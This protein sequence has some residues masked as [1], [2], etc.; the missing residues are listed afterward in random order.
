MVFKK[1]L[2]AAIP[3]I[4]RKGFMVLIILAACFYVA[5]L[6]PI[7]QNSNYHV[8]AGD[9]VGGVIPILMNE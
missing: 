8:F 6:P 7:H 9:G 3:L 4:L 5:W 2:L 1:N